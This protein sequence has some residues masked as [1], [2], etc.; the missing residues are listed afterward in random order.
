VSGHEGIDQYEEALRRLS[1][2]VKQ[3]ADGTLYLT[4]E[5][6]REIGVTDPVAFA[7]FKRSLEETNKKVRRGELKV[8]QE[9]S[10]THPIS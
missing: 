9:W 5:D 10:S 3:A 2:Y 8:G 7:D 1:S 6:G 4:I